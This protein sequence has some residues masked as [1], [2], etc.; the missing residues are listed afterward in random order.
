MFCGVMYSSE[1]VCRYK[2]EY[3]QAKIRH[4][5]IGHACELGASENCACSSVGIELDR[6][7]EVVGSIPTVVIPNM[8]N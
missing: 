7:T 3:K 2:Q 1:D 4:A 5:K 6:Q 8:S